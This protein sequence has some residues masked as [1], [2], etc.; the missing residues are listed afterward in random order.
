MKL[1][2][3]YIR[4]LLS[5]D[6]AARQAFAQELRDDP[7]WDP[8][9]RAER[10]SDPEKEKETYKQTFKVGRKLKTLFAK[11]ADRAFLDSL[12]TIHWGTP[13]RILDVFQNASSRDELS[14]SVYLPGDVGPSMW[15]RGT[16]L[17]VKGHITILSN[18]MNDLMTGKGSVAKAA[19]PERAKMSGANKGVGRGYHPD[20]YE[21]GSSLLVFDEEDWEPE[22]AGGTHTNN[23]ALVDN[24]KPVGIIAPAEKIDMF[25][26][27]AKKLKLDIPVVT[28]EEAE[29]LL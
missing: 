17:V 4:S 6:M 24:W 22:L 8:Q 21:T 23:E 1:L 26:W 29:K 5:E 10:S 12:V 19:D 25:K 28:M 11:H 16:G 9:F 3:K 27:A 7:E 15:G 14:T 13:V 2:R 18:H 20:T